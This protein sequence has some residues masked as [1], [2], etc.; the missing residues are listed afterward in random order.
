VRRQ[1]QAP[2]VESSTH[3]RLAFGSAVLCIVAILL[4]GFASSALG[5][6][7]HPY[8]GISFGPDGVGGTESFEDVGSVAADP[9][10]GDVYVYDVGAGKIYKFD[11]AGA[12]VSFSATGTNAISNV[13]VGRSIALNEIALA[14]A[15]SPAGTAGDIYVANFDNGRAIHVYSPAGAEL[16]EVSQGSEICGV[17]TDPAGNF[18]TGVYPST[19]N[20]YT[21][22]TN[23]PTTADQSGTGTVPHSICNVAADGLGNV[24]AADFTGSEGLYKLEGITDATPTKVDPSANTMGIA[25]GSNDLY[26]NRGSVVVQ[27]DSA[28]NELGSFGEGDLS[29]SRGVAIN[30][31]ATK[32]YVGAGQKVKVFG[33]TTTLPDATTEA[34]TAITKHAGTLRG[35]IGAAGGPDA[36]C[37]FQYTTSQEF[38]SQGFTGALE[39]PC[40]PAGPFT[41][42]SSTSVSA[43]VTGLS[44]ETEYRFRLVGSS[45]NGSLG[46]P[47]LSF[48]T[49]GAV[50][51]T[52]GA[53]SVVAISSA[54]LNGTVNP[55]GVELEECFFEYGKTFALGSKVPC[56]ETPAAIG[57]GN[58]PVAVHADLAGLDSATEYRFRL[59]GKSELGSSTGQFAEFKTPGAAVE[60]ESV[61]G[62][63]PSSAIFKAQVNPKGEATS[64]SFEYVSEADFNAS[65]FAN[66]TQ[67]PSGGETIGT[68]TVGVEVEQEAIDL[69]P[70][71][72]YHLRVTATNA[73][74]DARGP[75]I[76]FS[77]FPTNGSGGLPDGRAYEQASSMKKDGGNIQGAIHT[78]KTSPSGEGI[79]FVVLGGLPEAEGGQD[80]GS[81]LARRGDSAWTTHGLLPSNK[82]GTGATVRGLSEDLSVEYF[83]TNSLS[84]KKRTFGEKN[85]YSN[86]YTEIRG[87][88]GFEW[89]GSF[90]PEYMGTSADNNLALFEAYEA[91][92]AGAAEGMP[93]A[94]IWDRARQQI[95][96]A[97]VFNDG[98]APVEGSNVGPWDYFNTGGGRIYYFTQ[99]QHVLSADG[100]KVFFTDA[101]THQLYMRV[102]PT[103][104]QSAMNGEECAEA[105]KAC[106][107]QVSKSQRSTPDPFGPQPAKFVTATADGS[108]VLFMSSEELTDDSNTGPEDNSN[109]LYSYDTNTHELTDLTP[110]TLAENPNGGEV[111]GVLGIS[112]DASYIYFGA[113][114]V[115]APGASAGKHCVDGNA[116]EGKCNIYRWHEGDVTQ[117]TQLEGQFWL[118][119]LWGPGEMYEYPHTARVSADGKTLMMLVP[120]NLTGY[121]S[122]GFKELYRFR[123][124]DSQPL[125]VSCMPS[126]EE[127]RG[128]TTLQS[129]EVGGIQPSHQNA[130]SSRNM[131]ASGNR[132][133]FESVDRLVGADTNGVKDV[134]EWEAEGTGSCMSSDQDGG[135]LYLISTGTSPEP[136]YFG[137]AGENGD[138]AY[139]FTAQPLVGQDRD[140]L[141][142]VYDARVGGGLASQNP[143]PPSIC[144]GEACRPGATPAPAGQ[145]AGTS[146]FSGPGNPPA[147]KS[148]HKKKHKSKK[149]Q[150]SKKHQKKGAKSRQGGNR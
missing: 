119:G 78:V 33:A 83:L 27:Y 93:N 19:I 4:A 11:S 5:A 80:F 3:R 94:Y 95:V 45:E 73:S 59:G 129:I 135:C 132:I 32:I 1:A 147:K 22:T 79:T 31:D 60:R 144:T 105:D 141:V 90:E 37:A 14:P 123:V 70:R 84:P 126:G 81:Y 89:P 43:T 69:T 67:I 56:A 63:T 41:G 48:A 115:F 138:D 114:G 150:K 137:D 30:A 112:K 127:P 46:G 75:E 136:S 54:T 143:P 39:V 120:Q 104:P 6:Q 108:K 9:S 40:S 102:N 42:S 20:K 13:G 146:T 65:G 49:P 64:Y 58:S 149:K 87:A 23:P 26:A 47:S 134:Y 88:S 74:G 133:F 71:T 99:E 110:S 35:T 122:R 72:T 53:A 51:V 106:T 98:Q 17:A 21:P 77:T 139:F 10:N 16:G 142:D 38:L 15:G 44:Q 140:E 107:Y 86:Q 97:G 103:Q 55:E 28:G 62:V 2:V 24:Y 25:P 118:S 111:S 130:F 145:S 18:Y 50:N 91:M 148:H 92:T 131:S 61:A 124:G 36:T 68:G 76:I 116:E 29:E 57:N 8:T 52:T 34:A 82:L 66:A 100:S 101:G 128:D 125:C 113:G 96:L 109:D 7:G 117:L 12:P 121:D 85:T